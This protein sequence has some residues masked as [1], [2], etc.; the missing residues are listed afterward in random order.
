[1]IGVFEFLKIT[2]ELEELIYKNPS[3]AEIFKAVKK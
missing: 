3:E 2:K 1:M